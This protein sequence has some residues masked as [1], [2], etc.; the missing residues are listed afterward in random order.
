MT[1]E[2]QYRDLDEGGFQRFNRARTNRGR[3]ALHR[4]AGL[5]ATGELDLYSAPDDETQALMA[6]FGHT[7]ASANV[8]LA[9]YEDFTEAYR[10]LVDV[11]IG[12]AG[13]RSDWFEANDKLI[14]MHAGRSAKWVQTTR[15][16]FIAWQQKHYA[17]VVDIED[18]LYDPQNGNQPHKYRV[19]LARLAAEATLDARASRE[20][21]AHP[22]KA[23]EQSAKNLRLMLPPPMHKRRKPD[24]PVDAASQI[25]R[26]L[27]HIGTLMD[28]VDEI[29]EATGGQVELDLAVIEDLENRLA[30]LKAA[31]VDPFSTTYQ[32]RV[33]EMRRARRSAAPVSPALPE[34]QHAQT[35]QV[36]ED[37]DIEAAADAAGSDESGDALALLERVEAVSGGSGNYFHSPLPDEVESI[38]CEESAQLREMDG[39]ISPSPDVADTSQPGAIDP[40]LPEK[41]D[42]ISH[43][44]PSPAVEPEIINERI[45]IM[46][47]SGDVSESE[48]AEIARRDLCEACRARRSPESDNLKGEAWQT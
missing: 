1:L 32:E 13:D 40:A 48:A 25:N 24:R 30:V 9:E 38:T 41:P 14:G 15:K 42:P 16:D 7:M 19:H 21:T 18:H 8:L 28:R 5:P 29:R 34:P 31:A 44:C 11:L 37:E 22:G 2:P 36:G 4:A 23:L 46:C 26:K 10:L 3:A 27:K 20:W 35:F 33:V 47:E 17:S 6:D 43:T 12:L 39:G 45:F